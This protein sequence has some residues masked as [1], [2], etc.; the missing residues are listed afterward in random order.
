MS[1]TIEKNQRTIVVEQ[2]TVTGVDCVQC[3]GAWLALAPVDAACRIAV[4]RIAA[5]SERVANSRLV[6]DRIMNG[7]EWVD[8]CRHIAISPT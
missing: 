6:N 3:G 7:R 4:W 2:Y 8:H 5:Q 1:T